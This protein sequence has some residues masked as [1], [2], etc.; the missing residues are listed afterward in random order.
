VRLLLERGADIGVSFDHG[1]TPL[2]LAGEACPA[3]F[4]DLLIAVLRAG[5][6]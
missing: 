5:E 3:D 4:V 6:H 2:T 1:K